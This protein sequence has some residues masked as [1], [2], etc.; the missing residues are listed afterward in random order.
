MRLLPITVT[1]LSLLLVIKANDLYFNSRQL[2]ELSQHLSWSQRAGRM[3]EVMRSS[4]T[5][6]NA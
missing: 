2:R 5:A 1:M 6:L 4:C 3:V